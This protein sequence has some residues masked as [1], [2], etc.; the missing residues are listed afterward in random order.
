[1]QKLQQPRLQSWFDM[2]CPSFHSWHI[3]GW[4]LLLCKKVL[5]TS[6]C[7]PGA[8]RAQSSQSTDRTLTGLYQDKGQTDSCLQGKGW[9]VAHWSIYIFFFCL[10]NS[11]VHTRGQEQECRIRPTYKQWIYMGKVGDL[12]CVKILGFSLQMSNAQTKAWRG[13]VIPWW[14]YWPESSQCAC[15]LYLANIYGLVS[16]KWRYKQVCKYVLPLFVIH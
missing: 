5:S 1:M 7:A 8:K 16:T 15:K 2:W 3:T 11:H 6:L 12:D 13:N 4:S 9:P 10:Q 14:L